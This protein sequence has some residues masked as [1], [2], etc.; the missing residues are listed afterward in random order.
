MPPFLAG[1]AT[2]RIPDT[3]LNPDGR[4]MRRFERQLK[5]ETLTGLQN[6]RERIF[7]DLT[8]QFVNLALQRLDS[9]R[10]VV[11]FRDRI[12][13]KLAE[14]SLAG[15]EFGRE[16]VERH[17]FGTK[18][19]GGL[20]I[21]WQLANNAAA[22]WARR[23]GYRLVS[24]LVDTTRQ[25]LQR[26]IAQFIQN[27]E[28]LGDLIERVEDV[29]SPARAELIAVTEVTRAFAE[30]NRAAWQES[31]VVQQREWR[32]NNDELVCPICGPLA[33]TVA[34]LDS[35]FEGGI[36]GP[37]AHPRCRC[38]VVPVVEALE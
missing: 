33:N 2:R 32:T 16:Q 37:P 15:A 34:P 14:I 3:E 35:P 31:G 25:R 28:T 22:E 4:Q 17:I 26:E 30:G 7:A 9:E 21:D 6:L 11:P 19:E 8:A 12:T 20:G 10:V 29:F 27:Q 38:W 36:D 1:K 23:Y 24:D 13:R 18:Q 5:D